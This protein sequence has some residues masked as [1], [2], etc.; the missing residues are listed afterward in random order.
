MS[1]A[2]A[3][4][5]TAWAADGYHGFSLHHGTWSAISS[6]GKVLTGATPR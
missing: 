3:E 6:A 4:L 5:E 1:A 2:R